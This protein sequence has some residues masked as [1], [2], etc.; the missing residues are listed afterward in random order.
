MSMYGRIHTLD[1]DP[2][3]TPHKQSQIGYRSTIFPGGEV[4]IKVDN[5]HLRDFGSMAV[6]TCRPKHPSDIIKILM[7]KDALDRQGYTRVDLVMPYI[8]YA[9]QDRVCN[10]GEA[11]SLKVF[12]DLINNA[13]FQRVT[14]FDP[15]S[16]VAPALLERLSVMDNTQYVIKAV[17]DFGADTILISPDAGAQKKTLK[18][19]QNKIGMGLVQCDKQRNVS[20]GKLSGFNVYAADLKGA[21][22]MI[23]D[24]ICDGGGTF[25]GLAK[26]LKAKG[27]GEI[28]LFV[29]HGIFSQ[30]VEPLLEH[31]DHVYCTDSYQTIS[32]N[33]LTQFKIEL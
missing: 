33:Q 4:H 29:T 17:H 27:A 14:V 30:D 19:A 21:R 32:H 10:P 15:H 2:D 18:L 24:D 5:F 13:N 7:A 16:D 1:L 3:F 31:I 23:V 22:C 20:T 26:E 12:C 25:I 11:F 9:R 28:S 8:P 6:L